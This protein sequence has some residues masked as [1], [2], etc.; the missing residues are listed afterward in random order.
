M[1]HTHRKKIEFWLD[2]GVW[3][4]KKKKKKKREE[5]ERIFTTTSSQ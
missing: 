2:C 1:N 4:E 5:R 3:H